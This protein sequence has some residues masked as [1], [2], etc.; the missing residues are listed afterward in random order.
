MS[1]KCR[2]PTALEFRINVGLLHSVAVLARSFHISHD[3]RKR[4]RFREIQNPHQDYYI[5]LGLRTT[6]NWLNM[7]RLKRSNDAACVN[8][9]NKVNVKIPPSS[10]RSN[11]LFR[12]VNQLFLHATTHEKRHNVPPSKI[13]ALKKQS[14]RTDN[15]RQA[16]TN[17]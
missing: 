6:A 15:E 7:N 14:L 9:S 4:R 17:L 16:K 5:S 11:T 10:G 2:L 1:I 8:R 3:I 12:A 13:P